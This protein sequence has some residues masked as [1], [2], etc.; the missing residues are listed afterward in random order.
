MSQS[1]GGDAS[2]RPLAR[3]DEQGPYAAEGAAPA[4]PARAPIVAIGASAG[5][6]EALRRLLG[7]LPLDAN[8]AIV[9]VQHL[10]PSH[11]SMLT[12]ALAPCT[13]LR[14]VEVRDGM[15]LEAGQVHVIP[16]NTTLVLEGG[17]LRLRPRDDAARPPMPI[18]TFMRS[19]AGL[20]E[21]AIGVVL[22]GAGSDGTQGLRAIQVAGGRTYAQ[23]PSTALHDAMPRSAIAADAVDLILSPQEIPR[24]TWRPSRAAPPR[25]RSRRTTRET[26][27]PRS[28]GSSTC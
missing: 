23:A 25:R 4:A 21:G 2:G 17:V 9:V 19:L 12:S 14:V 24:R 11:G 27:T 26:P 15:R 20:R 18:D 13:P 16:P 8:L 5:G 10:S 7:A 22:S 3:A 1:M 28:A 6:V